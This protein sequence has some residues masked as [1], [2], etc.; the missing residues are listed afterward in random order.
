[1][2][3]EKLLLAKK[4]RRRLMRSKGLNREAVQEPLRLTP[5]QKANLTVNFVRSQPGEG[6]VQLCSDGNF[7]QNVFL[8][9]EKRRDR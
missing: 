4:P 9:K 5:R 8:W 2:S 1:M 6:E 3:T 7:D